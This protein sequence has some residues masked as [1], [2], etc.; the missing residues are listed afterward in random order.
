MVIQP[1]DRVL[2]IGTG[3]GAIAAAA[4]QRTQEVVA[5]D[6]SPYAVQ[7][8][9]VTM[10]LNGLEQHVSVLLG[11]LFMPVH[12]EVFDVVLFNPPYFD[13]SAASWMERAWSAEP[14]CKLIERFLIGVRSVLKPGG[15][16]QMLLSSAAPLREILSL[17]RRTKY[18]W[19]ILA[20]GH[21][22]G[23]LERLFLFE[24]W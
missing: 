7:C 20:R 13:L 2:E 16:V 24:L 23:F 5:T 6:V 9:E 10:M 4:A 12:G 1:E 15:R 11:D 22:L 18:R 17:I 19:Q 3:T 21:I 8:A 14:G